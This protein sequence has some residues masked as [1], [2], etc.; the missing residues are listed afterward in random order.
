M[1]LINLVLQRSTGLVKNC[2][3]R[4][5]LK[6]PWLC[7][8]WCF[9]L[10]VLALCSLWIANRCYPLLLPD[11][12]QDFASVV[13]DDQGYPLRA[14]ADQQGVWRYK[15]DIEDV[16]DEYL[17]ALIAYEDRYFYQHPGVN[18]IS[19]LRAAWQYLIHQR[20]VSGGSTITMQV[21]RILHPHRRTLL[22][23]LQQ[24]LRALQL[25]WYLSKQEILN[26]YINYA[27]FGGTLEGVQ[28]ASYQ[29]FR[30][31]A[32]ALRPA[33]AVLLAVLPQAPSRYRPDRYP[34]RAT[35]ARNKVIDRLVKQG[36]WSTQKGKQVKQE[37]VVVWKPEQ[38][39]VAPLLA[40]RLHQENPSKAVINTYIKRDLQLQI[41]SYVHEYAMLQGAGVSMAV[42]VVDNQTQHVV[43]YVGSASMLDASRAG[44]VDMI[45]AIRS[46]GSTLKPLLF[47]L[48]ID[49]NLIHSQ[50]LLADVP[51]LN[52]RYQPG[53]FAKGFDGPV[54][55]TDALQ[56]SLNIPFVQLIE[57]YG[58]QKFV[59]KLAHVLYPLRIPNGQANASVILGG[60][61]ISLQSLVALH[62][63]FANQ[64]WVKPL[65][66]NKGEVD[67]EPETADKV[68]T[69]KNNIAKGRILVSDE[70]AWITWKTLTGLTPPV[71]FSWGVSQQVR[72][73]LAWKTGTSWSSRD[74]W[75]IGST[76]QYS[77]GVW[78]GKPSGEPLKGALGV[79][80]AAPALFSV[81]S[82]LNN[83]KQENIQSIS[84]TPERPYN[85]QEKEICWPDG[86]ASNLSEGNC[87]RRFVAL[88][89]GGV[90]PRT[91]QIESGLAFHQ[92]IENI[93]IDSVS[94][95]RLSEHC[96]AL[97]VKYKKVSVWPR[98]LE[99]W[100][101]VNEKRGQR[102]PIYSPHCLVI[103]KQADALT[104]VG[105]LNQQQI[106]RQQQ[107]LIQ[108]I[109]YAAGASGQVSWY[110]NGRWLATQ[111]GAFTLKLSPQLQGKAELVAIDQHGVTGRITFTMKD[112]LISL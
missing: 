78:V 101:A 14:F 39:F 37:P 58:E 81:L 57:A 87:D 86:R 23:K 34:Q 108:Q 15:V 112:D 32:L 94:G 67:I 75:A 109:V 29:Y 50:S 6:W 43:S 27:P 111:V 42:L 59:N 104:I 88:T 5:L 92:V 36:D 20:I 48:A 77:I 100:L 30:K 102:I 22:G 21:A 1:H 106:Y 44:H 69:S 90:T 10:I 72:P 13:L 3:Y 63:S 8:V 99:P 52:S 4:G 41:S 95:L 74:A 76:E 24:V 31:P 93:I 70:A 79:T 28:A 103:P 73:L 54:T 46:P 71:Q 45:Q 56:R 53:N 49:D 35:Q 65:I 96:A 12:Q 61:G 62:S 107:E 80:T 60:A 11:Q 66:F 7:L 89:K 68:N 105:L 64:G 91:L 26:I 47:A 9:V 83:A 2:A 97:A 16:S 55:A 84:A 51:R 98:Q 82:M 18:P 38:P 33:E 110:L 85:V 40:R 17:L 19:F 25:E